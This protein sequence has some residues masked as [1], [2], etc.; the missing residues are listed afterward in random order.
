MEQTPT[1]ALGQEPKLT[2]V[3]GVGGWEDGF[4]QLHGY[5]VLLKGVKVASGVLAPR[6]P[7]EVLKANL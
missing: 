7:A 3:A 1:P 2:V 6:L 5:C 4:W